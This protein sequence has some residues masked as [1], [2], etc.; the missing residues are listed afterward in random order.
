MSLLNHDCLP[1]TRSVIHENPYDFS[2]HMKLYASTDI[3][4]GECITQQYVPVVKGTIARRK[5]LKE[6][7]FDCSCH[8]CCDP[9]EFRTYFSC[10]KCTKCNIGFLTP[11]DPLK[12]ETSFRC[13]R[14]QDCGYTG[15]FEEVQNIIKPF[16][17]QIKEHETASTG[18]LNC[19]LKKVLLEKAFHPQ[20]Y[21]AVN[22]QYEVVQRVVKGL[23]N[24]KD[25]EIIPQCIQYCRNILKVVNILCPGYS[26]YRGVIL[27][28]LGNLLYT[29]YEEWNN[30]NPAISTK[31]QNRLV[32]VQEMLQVIQEGAIIMSVE[33]DESIYREM[34]DELKSFE[35]SI[36]S[37][38]S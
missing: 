10:I 29:L 27:Y 31:E 16:E 30:E 21:V 8:R 22:L 35:A 7:F 33:P 4:K 28:F 1:N 36:K 23:N 15:S 25:F 19:L 32:S 24:E 38:Y 13:S 12:D 34:A 2:L 37:C 11:D 20:H 17:E 6:W 3:W 9:T 18:A 26:Y 5:A 14:V